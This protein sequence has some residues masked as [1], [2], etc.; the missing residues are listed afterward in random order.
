MHLAVVSTE[1]QMSLIR[2]LLMH[3]ADPHIVDHKGR[4]P[5]QYAK[6]KN[7]ESDEWRTNVINMLEDTMEINKG[8]W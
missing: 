6:D 5:L 3:G 2:M 1:M 8:V 4:T 7:K